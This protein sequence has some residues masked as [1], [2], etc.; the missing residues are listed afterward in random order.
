MSPLKSTNWLEE[1]IKKVKI[2]DA[3][4]HMPNSNRNAFKEYEQNHIKSSIFFDLDENSNKNISLPHMMPELQDWEKIVSKLG[5][6]NDDHIIIYD[7]SEVLSASRCWFTFLYFGHDINLVS[8]LDGGLKKWKLENRPLSTEKISLVE[9]NYKARA[10][11]DLIINLNQVEDNIKEKKFCLVDARVENRFKGL[12][13]EPR[14]NLKKGSIK[15][16][17]NLPFSKIINFENNTF[18]KKAELEKIF[19]NHGI[20][21]NEQLAFSC[22]SGI[23]A[24]VLGLANT[25]INNKLPVIYDGSWAEY[26][27]K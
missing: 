27:L 8:V 15:G 2:L 4:W 14:K 9:T 1:N 17:K 12:V 19:I 16:S 25:I 23:T 10:K 13:E 21:P 5:I 11:K 7:N 20:K 3:T 22:G 26:G 18:K 6:K 24:C